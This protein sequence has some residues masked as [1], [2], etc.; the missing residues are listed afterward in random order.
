MVLLI[1]NVAA[2]FAAAVDDITQ[3]ADQVNIRFTSQLIGNISSVFQKLPKYFDETTISRFF[4]PFSP[5]SSFIFSLKLNGS[6]A[7]LSGN[8]TKLLLS[9]LIL[10]LLSFLL[11]L[12][13]ISK[14]ESCG[15]LFQDSLCHCY[16]ID[17]FFLQI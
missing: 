16:L 2:W 14:A 8:S 12:L 9:L 10:L 4:V 1:A 5:V 15:T 13:L 7:F 6:A 17:L 11:S 3:F